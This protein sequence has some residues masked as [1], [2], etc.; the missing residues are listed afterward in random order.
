MLIVPSF[1]VRTLIQSIMCHVQE[2][3]DFATLHPTD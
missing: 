1:R 3:L 2:A